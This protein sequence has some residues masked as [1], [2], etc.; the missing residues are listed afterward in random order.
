MASPAQINANRLNATKSTGPRTGEGKAASR[1]NSLQHGADARLDIIPGEDP[2]DLADLARSY[3]ARFRPSAPDEVFLV[4][5]LIQSDWLRRRFRRIEAELM[6]HLLS[7]MEPCANPLGVLFASNTPGARALVRVRRH[8]EAADRAWFRALKELQSLLD[9]A[10]DSIL[11]GTS[12]PIPA[13]DAEP[14][15]AQPENWLRSPIPIPIAPTAPVHD[16]GLALRL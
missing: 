11:F 9:L 7:E 3:R 5:T 2:A 14:A 1:L 8:Y 15:P 4:E 16:P 12:D 6:N 10:A 13:P